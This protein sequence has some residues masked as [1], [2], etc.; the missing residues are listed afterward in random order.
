MIT[1]ASDFTFRGSSFCGSP[2]TPARNS[3]R[4]AG[5]FWFGNI[6]LHTVKFANCFNHASLLLFSQ[7]IITRQAQQAIA[8]VFCNGAAP[9][10]ASESAPHPREM[11]RQVVE[12]R[13]DTLLLQVSNERLAKGVTRTTS[14]VGSDKWGSIG[15]NEVQGARMELWDENF[16]CC[17]LRCCE[18]QAELGSGVA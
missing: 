1:T 9:W 3:E 17:R 11:Q 12:Y 4:L 10:F 14:G 15:S 16:G 6:L 13:Q 8:Y 5:T 2:V 7:I 18:L